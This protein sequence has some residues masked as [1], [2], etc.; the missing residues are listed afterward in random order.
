MNLIL[1]AIG[2]VFDPNVVD[3]MNHLFNMNKYMLVK[4]EKGNL[5]CLQHNSDIDRQ[6][7][8]A[9]LKRQGLDKTLLKFEMK[10]M[11]REELEQIIKY[12]IV[13]LDEELVLYKEVEEKAKKYVIDK[14]TGKF[15]KH[16]FNVYKTISEK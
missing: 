16:G 12:K 1:E 15:P 3:G 6:I 14:Y 2:G 13:M 5:I 11:K 7:I 8:E 4:D 9:Y 10:S